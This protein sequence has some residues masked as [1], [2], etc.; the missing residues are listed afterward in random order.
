[1]TRAPVIYVYVQAKK[2]LLIIF[3]PHG[4]TVQIDWY[5]RIPAARYLPCVVCS[6]IILEV[7]VWLLNNDIFVLIRYGYNN[8]GRC[9]VVRVQVH[10]CRHNVNT[11]VVSVN[12]GLRSTF[13]IFDKFVCRKMSIIGRMY[14]RYV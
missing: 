3:D 11:P 6:G 9:L 13:K 10:N 8:S 5:L 1:M 14:T 4:M 12:C 7:Y 2:K